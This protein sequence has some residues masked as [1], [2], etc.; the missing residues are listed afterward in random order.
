MCIRDRASLLRGALTEQYSAMASALAQMASRLG[1]A[2]LPDPRREAKV[3]N[4]FSTLGLEPLECSATSDVAGRISVNVTIPRMKFTDVELQ[5]LARE[6]GRICRRDFDLPDLAQCRTVSMLRFGERPLFTPA[7]GLAS[8]P[9]PPETVSGDACDQFCDRA[10]RAQMLLCDGM[11]LSLIHISS[12]Q[13]QL[14][15]L[16]NHGILDIDVP[17]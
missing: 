16:H 3:A 8:R 5:A 2:G 11:G 1:Q 4:L 10:G 9:A 14:T 7:F 17:F 6:V 12:T 15:F 13:I